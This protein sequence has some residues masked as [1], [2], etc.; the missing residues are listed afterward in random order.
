MA[1]APRRHARRRSSGPSRSWACGSGYLAPA[2]LALFEGL[3]PR[4][5]PRP[6][7]TTPCCTAPPA[8]SSFFIARGE[9]PIFFRQRPAESRTRTTTRRCACRSPT[10]RRSSRARGSAGRVRP[11]RA[12]RTASSATVSAFPCR[13]VPVSG[14]LFGADPDFDE[15][16]AAR[17]E[18]LPGF[19]AVYGRVDERD[20]SNFA[21]RPFRDDRPVFAVGGPL[22]WSARCCSSPTSGSLPT[23]AGEVAGH[24]R[25]RSRRS[26]GAASQRGPARS[27]GG[28][29]GARQL[30]AFGPGGGEPRPVAD[31]RGAALLLDRRCSRGSSGRCRPDVGLVRLQPRFDEAGEIEL[32]HAA[33]RPRRATPSCGRSRRSRRTPR[34]AV[35]L[36]SREPSPEAGP[37]EHRSVHDSRPV[38]PGGAAVRAACGVWRPPAAAAGGG[39]AL[40]RPATSVFFLRTARAAGTR[41]EALEARRDALTARR[42]GEEAEAAQLAGQRDRLTGVSSAIDEFY[43]HRI[44]SRARDARARSS[45][46]CT[47]S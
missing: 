43:G 41:R 8:R 15:R 38:R 39:R 2:S 19:A 29:G 18:L 12:R 30:Q 14:R 27:A 28:A 44:G 6:R 34:S 1:A 33:R 31:R 20:R 46:S 36:R 24:A 40:R 37:E 35:E 10:T 13:R 22:S 16:I 9:A 32:E 42:R 11:R 26:R 7:A 5:R 45:P 17:P 23:I 47:P 4:S 21:R 25:R 3:A